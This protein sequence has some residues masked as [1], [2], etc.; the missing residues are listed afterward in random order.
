MAI[1]H[2]IRPHSLAV[3]R[4]LFGSLMAFAM[5]RFLAN[6]WIDEFFLQPQFHFTYPG[7]GWIRPWPGGWMHAHV[8][9]LAV[10]GIF[11]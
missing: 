6:G 2:Q 10:P 5:L 9:A 7:F 4:I 1:D 8:A 3:F 11:S